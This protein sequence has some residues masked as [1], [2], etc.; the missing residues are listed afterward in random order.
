LEL[1][2]DCKIPKVR[3]FIARRLAT[4]SLAGTK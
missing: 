2:K 1:L 3:E 4:L